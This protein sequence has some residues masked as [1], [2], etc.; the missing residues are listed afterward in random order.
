MNLR[1][2]TTNQT[3]IQ[4]EEPIDRTIGDDKDEILGDEDEARGDM[5]EAEEGLLL[6]FKRRRSHSA[7]SSDNGAL[8]YNIVR[9]DVL[10]G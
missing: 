9:G 6:G 7:E 1:S 2:K 4:R 5:T 8:A 10:S 3:N